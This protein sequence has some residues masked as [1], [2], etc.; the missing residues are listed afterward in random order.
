MFHVE[1]GSSMVVLISGASHT[2][3]T[4]IAKRLMEEL[5]FPYLSIDHLKMGLIRS[6]YTELTVHDDDKLTAYL[7]PII[8]ESIK[9]VI[10]NEQDLIIEGCYIPFDWTQEFEPFYLK[11]IRYLCIV[12]SEDYIKGHF[13]DILSHANDI[14]HRISDECGMEEL[15]RDNAF[16]LNGCRKWRLPYIFIESDYEAEL[17]EGIRRMLDRQN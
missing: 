5:H 16:Y 6:G 8:R 2:G 3:K 13:E 1:Q 14:E 7:W 17:M 9:T 12:M 15:I 11:H 10:E 4:H